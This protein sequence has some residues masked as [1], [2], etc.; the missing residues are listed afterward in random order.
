VSDVSDSREMLAAAPLGSWSVD[1]TRYP[2][3]VIPCLGPRYDR[4]GFPTYARR[5]EG[6]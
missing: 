1:E 3:A 2:L 5:D 4:N 6:E